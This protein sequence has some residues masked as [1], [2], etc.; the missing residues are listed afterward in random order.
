MIQLPISGVAHADSDKGNA[1]PFTE[2]PCRYHSP[3]WALRRDVHQREGFPQNRG[4]AIALMHTPWRTAS[5]YLQVD[6]DFDSE[7]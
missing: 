6:E 5:T 4:Q 2:E 3:S 1:R 7:G